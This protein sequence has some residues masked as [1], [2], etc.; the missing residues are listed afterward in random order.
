MGSDAL[1]VIDIDSADQWADNI[2]DLTKEMKKVALAIRN[3]LEVW[4]KAGKLIIFVIF[5]EADYEGA[6]YQIK[7]GG[8]GCLGCNLILPDHLTGFLKHRHGADFEPVF[9]KERNNAFSNPN[10]GKFL[11]KQGVT[12][13][14]LTGYNTWACVLKTAQGAVRHG[15]EV[16]LIKSCVHPQFLKDFHTKEKWLDAVGW[17]G[18]LR[19]V[20]V[21]SHGPFSLAS[22]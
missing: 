1:L 7:D 9:S 11:R 5:P 13:L 8:R 3:E 12:K 14:W 20:A 22:T 4:R 2:T 16:A 19:P 10:L 6:N 21:L 18:R 17:P 15:F